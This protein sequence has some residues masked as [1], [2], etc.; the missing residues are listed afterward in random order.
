MS[1]AQ[2][3]SP[4]E[5][6]RIGSALARY[7][8]Q[9]H[10]PE[11]ARLMCEIVVTVGR[12]LAP[13]GD[14][15]DAFDRLRDEERRLAGLLR[16]LAETVIEAHP[17]PSES[18]QSV[19]DKSSREHLLFVYGTLKRGHFRNSVLSG[20]TFLGDVS[21]MP[22]YRL[23]DCGS[24]PALVEV[25][26]GVSVQGELWRVEPECIRLLDDIEGVDR[27]LYRR[28]L[29]RLAPPHDQL[30]VEAYFY[31]RRVEGLPDCGTTWPRQ[32]ARS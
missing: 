8:H 16:E 32:T 23:Y 26:R 2:S 9:S 17:A 3:P 4:E 27:G 14:S 30:T 24:Y 21:T 22:Y 31:C 13:V 12:I 25:D 19:P 7:L 5:F 10:C 11:V 28:G 15:R 29:V 18:W 20:Q 1:E 6:E